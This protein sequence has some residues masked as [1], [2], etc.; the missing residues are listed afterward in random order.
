MNAQALAL[1][2]VD[3]HQVVNDINHEIRRLLRST[4]HRRGLLVA[5]SGGIDSSVSAALAVSAIGKGKVFGLLLPET[6]SAS[7]SLSNGEILAGWLKTGARN[8]LTYQ[9][10]SKWTDRQLVSNLFQ[11]SLSC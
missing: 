2:D 7:S 4:L 11:E 6:D 1:L 9:L 10:E 8:W 3:H 5:I